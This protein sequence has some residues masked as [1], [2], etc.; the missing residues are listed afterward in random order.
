MIKLQ[1]GYIY[2]MDTNIFYE[3]TESYNHQRAKETLFDL[4]IKGNVVIIDDKHNIYEDVYKGLHTNEFLHIES[5]LLKS[6][7]ASNYCPNP[8]FSSKELPCITC[9]NFNSQD[10]K[11]LCDQK[12]YCGAFEKLPCRKCIELNYEPITTD[13]SSYKI[14]GFTPDIAYG[15]DNKFKIWFEVNYQNP[16]SIAKRQYCYNNNIIL[17]EINASKIKENSKILP[18]TNLSSE[19][20]MLDKRNQSIDDAVNSLKTN[21]YIIRKDLTDI[22]KETCFYNRDVIFETLYKDFVDKYNL[23]ELL[24]YDEEIC[25]KFNLHNLVGRKHLLVPK[26]LA[27]DIL[28]FINNRRIQREEEKLNKKA[29]DSVGN[30]V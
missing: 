26:E 4:L 18:F 1:G 12:S 15:Y 17:L 24:W 30:K 8:M 5:F 9:L 27:I 11:L 28:K 16:C 2:N 7:S 25:Q 19:N 23:S 29:G 6:P 22:L 10:H 21:G 14:I 20:I 13:L 3:N